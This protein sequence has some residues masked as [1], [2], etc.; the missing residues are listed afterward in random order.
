MQEELLI[1]QINEKDI[2][3]F[4]TLY[5]RF[6]TVL[7]SYVAEIILSD[8]AAE[9]IVQDLFV[10]IWENATLQFPSYLSFR[11]YLYTYLRNAALNYLTHQSVERD[12]ATRMADLPE[13]PNDDNLNSEENYRKLFALLDEL[14]EQCRKVFLLALEG[15]KNKEIADLMQLSV[16]TVKTQK[17]RAMQKIKEQ[18]FFLFLVLLH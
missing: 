5:D 2:K 8:D 11:R 17:M 1:A 3:G 12:Y 13:A 7:V 6:Y 15:K 14:P 4:R 9:D 18:L 10:S 16:N